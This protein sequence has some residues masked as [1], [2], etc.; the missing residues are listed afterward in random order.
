MALSTILGALIIILTLIIAFIIFY[1]L[2][3]LRNPRIKVP[4]GNN[5]VSPASGKI[6]KI[7][8]LKSKT[9]TI[10]KWTFGR[11]KTLTTNLTKP[12]YLICIMMT[13]FDV[14]YQKAPIDGSVYSIMHK[15]GK[16]R[17]AMLNAESLRAAIEN[18]RNEII[19]DSKI[20]RIKVI[21][22]AGLFARRVQCF[23]ERYENIKKGED[24]GI[25]KL[26][27]Q[28][29]LIIP[30]LDLKV[31]EGDKVDAGETIIAEL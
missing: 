4:K 2:V 9:V 8:E 30:K 31:K 27:S 17:N 28:V 23:V 20:G 22:I 24:I 14:H 10:N 29:C 16:L 15:K 6:I 12:H 26:G 13:P 21:Q 3:F 25:I 19:I 18:E 1:G 5:L 7:V 11:I